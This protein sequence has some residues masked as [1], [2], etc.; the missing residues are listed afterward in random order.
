MAEII[1]WS[2]SIIAVILA[3]IVI[4]AKNPVRSAIALMGV[5]LSFAGLYLILDSEFI[6]G[7][8]I[9]VYIGGITVLYM[10]VISMMRFKNINIESQFSRQWLAAIISSIVF[11]I[12]IIY[13]GLKGKD[14]FK[15]KGHENIAVANG[16]GTV[17]NV[18]KVLY[19]KYVLP[20]EVATVLL[21]AAIIGTV[22]LA[23]KEKEEETE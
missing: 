5:L 19:G 13:F 4:L 11:F 18:G 10:F 17:E 15:I 14:F 8:Q 9:L 2:L 6:A 23:R 7:V 3:F 20:F 22:L 1:F 21:L 12:E 16:L